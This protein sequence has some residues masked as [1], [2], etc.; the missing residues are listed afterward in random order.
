MCSSYYMTDPDNNLYTENKKHKQYE[1]A[2]LERNQIILSSGIS[3]MK[4]NTFYF[5]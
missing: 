2:I 3:V 1:C 5:M 4:L